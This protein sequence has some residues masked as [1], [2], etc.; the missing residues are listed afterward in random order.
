LA[1]CLKTPEMP[2]VAELPN[3]AK[4]NRG[5]ELAEDSA[6]LPHS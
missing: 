1:V 2:K 6:A 4:M 3:S 5:G